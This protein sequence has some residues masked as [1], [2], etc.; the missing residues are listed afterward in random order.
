MTII[1]AVAKKVVKKSGSTDVSKGSER[2]DELQEREVSQ[3]D[4]DLK[5]EELMGTSFLNGNM[6]IHI[7]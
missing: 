6:I 7:W 1:S 2:S 5:A 4:V 3:D